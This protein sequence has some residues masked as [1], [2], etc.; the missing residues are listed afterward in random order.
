MSA[1]KLCK[2]TG[3]AEFVPSIR[4][5]LNDPENWMTTNELQHTFECPSVLKN[6]MYLGNGKLWIRWSR[7]LFGKLR[8]CKASMKQPSKISGKEWWST[9]TCTLIK[10]GDFEHLR[11]SLQIGWEDAYMN[12]RVYP[13]SLKPMYTKRKHS[14]EMLLRNWNR[15]W[16]KSAIGSSHSSF[17]LV[18]AGRKWK[19]LEAFG[20]K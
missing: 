11:N 6:L 15:K 19:T 20:G 18:K 12:I 3:A 8:N 9:N 13:N 1:K 16:A 14:W 2:S 17:S 4:D 10:S 7:T 5:H